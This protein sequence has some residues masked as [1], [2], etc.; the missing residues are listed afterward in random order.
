MVKEASSGSPAVPRAR[1]RIVV[2]G[3]GSGR[4]GD[5]GIGGLVAE[6]LG[7]RVPPGVE[8]LVPRDVEPDAVSDLDGATHILAID[9]IDIGRAPG[10]VV[11]YEGE[12]LRPCAVSASMLDLDV[13][14][15]LVLVGQHADAPEEVTLLGVQL[16]G[17]GQ[18]LSPEVAAVVPVLIDEAMAVLL[19]WLQ[20]S[21]AGSGSALRPEPPP[22]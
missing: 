22:C 1:T 17:S 16:G 18:D 12:S 3:A 19:G 9:C 4:A 7:E 15:L 10:T 2:L 14:N 13:A 6:A 5:R 20:S 21:P 8:I 11:L